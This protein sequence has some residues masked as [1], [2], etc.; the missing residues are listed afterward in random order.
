MLP[1][2]LLRQSR[3]RNKTRI[4]H[5]PDEVCLPHAENR[6]KIEDKRH[7]RN[8]QQ[9]MK[10]KAVSGPHACRNQQR[11]L[12]HS[13]MSFDRQQDKMCH[14]NYADILLCKSLETPHGFGLDV[15]SS[16]HLLL[17]LLRS[18]VLGCFCLFV[19]G[20]LPLKMAPFFAL[21]T[22]LSRTSHT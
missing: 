1:R 17:L 22:W 10:T 12:R 3:I 15:G 21:R 18:C 6:R 20:L 7:I 4:P 11:C 14:P 13:S 2:A 19:D 9:W 5:V 16:S 8:L